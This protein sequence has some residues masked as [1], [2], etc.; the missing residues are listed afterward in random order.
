MHDRESLYGNPLPMR[1]NE[2]TMFEHI[3][4]IVWP[5]E[6]PKAEF[7]PY[8]ARAADVA[9]IMKERIE[10]ASPKMK[11]EHIGSTAVPDCPGKGIVDMMTLYPDGYFE[12]AVSLLN[13]MGFQRQG[14]EFRN[15]FP[16]E[17]PVMM[18]TFEYDSTPFLVYIHV[19]HKDSYE[20]VRFRIF[21][22][23]LR[24]NPEHLAAYVDVK[25]KIIYEGISNSDEYV[26][27]KRAIIEEI[28]G[29]DYTEKKKATE[30]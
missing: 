14:P 25:K 24:S 23:R 4:K 8:D 21:R 19:I 13:A 3:E 15:R 17:R 12:Q 20:A 26:E 6:R 11:V 22:D 1:Y 28:L 27:R 5:Y 7:H 29:D 9:R 30:K 10:A 2:F 18:G 16:D